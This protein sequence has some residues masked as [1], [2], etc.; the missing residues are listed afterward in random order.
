M[1]WLLTELSLLSFSFYDPQ[2]RPSLAWMHYL[3]TGNFRAATTAAVDCASGVPLV[4]KSSTLLSIAKLSAKLAMDSASASGGG[5]DNMDGVERGDGLQSVARSLLQSPVPPA[6]PGA[7]A[8]SS[9]AARGAARAAAE[10]EFP[11]AVQQLNA[12][13][14]V[15]RAQE[16]VQGVLPK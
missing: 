2:T 4:A 11:L 15:L 1:M 16:I 8:A 10:E 5:G 6:R 12:D 7:A 3:R 14:A 13:L 9:F